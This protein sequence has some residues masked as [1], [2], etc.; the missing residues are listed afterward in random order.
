MF[1]RFL[2]KLFQTPECSG[3]D[4]SSNGFRGLTVHPSGDR[5][6]SATI[7]IAPCTEPTASPKAVHAKIGI[8]V[9]FATPSRRCRSLTRPISAGSATRSA[10]AAPGRR[11]WA[12]PGVPPF[13]R[14]VI[15]FSSRRHGHR[16]IGD[17]DGC[18]KKSCTIRPLPLPPGSGFFSTRQ[19]ASN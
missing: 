14:G 1:L 12:I 7:V 13:D 3:I 18:R 16:E 8:A 9:R 6:C 10:A 5:T 11:N 17:T 15:D 2:T 4:Q 19:T